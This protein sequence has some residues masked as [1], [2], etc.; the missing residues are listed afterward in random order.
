[1]RWIHDYIYIKIQEEF[2]VCV[3]WVKGSEGAQAMRHLIT[4]TNC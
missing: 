2:L 4:M 3:F 1:M